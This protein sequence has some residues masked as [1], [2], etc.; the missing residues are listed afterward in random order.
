VKIRAVVADSAV[1]VS[2]KVRV[3]VFEV[4]LLN[5]IPELVALK[6]KDLAPVP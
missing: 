6:A 5:A 4:A 3:N 1:R 2:G